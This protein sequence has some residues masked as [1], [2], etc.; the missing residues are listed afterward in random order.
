MTVTDAKCCDAFLVNV[1]TVV[2]VV[3]EGDLERELSLNCTLRE[4]ADEVP[5]KEMNIT[6]KRDHCDDAG[7]RDRPVVRR[8]LPLERVDP[9]AIV[10]RL[11]SLRMVKAITN[12]ARR[13]RS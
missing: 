1:A 13:T 4:T 8:V 9:M 12:S 10:N 11:E 7:C 2:G 6:R 5:L 3:S